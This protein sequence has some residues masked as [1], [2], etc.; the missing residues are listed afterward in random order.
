MKIALCGLP[1]SGKSTVF[2]AL[3]AKAIQ[4]KTAGSGKI[5]LNI[6]TLE[7]KDERLQKLAEILG[8]QKVTYPKIS[9]VDLVYLGEAAAKGMDTAA[10]REFDALALVIGAF[11]SK[12]PLA[13]LK[14]IESEFILGDLQLVQ[15]RIERIHKERK[16]APKKEDDPELLLLKRLVQALE[17]ET[18]LKGLTLG[19]DELKILAGFQLLTLKPLLIVANV[20]EEQLKNQGCRD[21]KKQVEAGNEK[22]F[23]LCAK[24]ETEIEELAEEERADF[25]KELGLETLSRERFIQ[26]C[27][28]AQNKIMFFTVVGKEARAWAIT[29]GISALGAAGSVHSDMERGFIRAEVINYRDFAECGSFAK[30]KEKGLLRLESKEYPVQDGDII[31]F[32]FS[33]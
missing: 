29:Q 23:S 33:V 15:N 19:A 2:K 1:F 25:M 8:S 28:Q 9:L 4:P 31:N 26:T 14:N 12:D 13:D 18:L 3:A 6:A 10:L 16:G 11:S 24:L 21:L 30:A 7:V 22:F 5:Q 17:A 27:F 20:S 32:K